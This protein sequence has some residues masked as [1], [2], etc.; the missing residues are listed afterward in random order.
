MINTGLIT[1]Y[2]DESLRLL[3]QTEM[4]LFALPNHPLCPLSPKAWR[5][6]VDVGVSCSDGLFVVDR[7]RDIRWCGFHQHCSCWH[8]GK[9]RTDSPWSPLWRLHV[10]M[11]EEKKWGV[12]NTNT[13]NC[14]FQICFVESPSI[15]SVFF[16]AAHVDLQ[17]K[18]GCNWTCLILPCFCLLNNMKHI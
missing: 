16:A 3:S 13:L 11:C 10:S 15:I 12:L 17:G 14:H 5:N 7:N 1:V 6:A 2:N 9:V 8:T 4:D 18:C